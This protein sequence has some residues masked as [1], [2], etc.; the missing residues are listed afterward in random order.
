MWVSQILPQADRKNNSPVTR[1]DALWRV[2]RGQGI[3]M[4][5]KRKNAPERV[6][7]ALKSIFDYHRAMR[8]AYRMIEVVV[9]AAAPATER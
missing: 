2:K 8:S 1:W 5:L 6:L 3:L 4:P 9:L 7:G